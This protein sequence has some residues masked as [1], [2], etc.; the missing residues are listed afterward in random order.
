MLRGNKQGAL[1]E[2]ETTCFGFVNG[3]IIVWVA[4]EAGPDRVHGEQ[5]AYL[6]VKKTL[7]GEWGSET[8]REDSQPRMCHQA[9]YHKGVPEPY[10]HRR[11]LEAT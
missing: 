8:G 6:E 11:N 5:L 3:R 9:S 1:K 7:V 10:F 4:S 2:A